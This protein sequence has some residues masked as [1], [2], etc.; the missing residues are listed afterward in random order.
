MYRLPS[1]DASFDLVTLDRVL[2]HAER[3]EAA[4]TEAAR[5][6]KAGGR[7]LIIERFDDIGARGGNPLLLLRR[8]IAAAGLE[9][10]RL[11]P[12]EVESGHYLIALAGR[13]AAQRPV[14]A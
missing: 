10:Q 2:V 1:A 9:T 5:T 6:L 12:C 7:L 4:L 14:A 8:W 13:A 11:H 3:P